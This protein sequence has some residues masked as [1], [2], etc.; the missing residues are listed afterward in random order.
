M[1]QSCHRV[2][3]GFTLIELVAVIIIIAVASAPL[4]GLFSQA[5]RSLLADETI[6]TATQLAQA[7]AEHLMAVRRNR[8]YADAEVSANL[9]ETLTGNYA[10]YSRVTTIAPYIGAACPGG[11]ACKQVSVRVDE[12]GQALAEIIFVLVNY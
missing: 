7:R 1:S 10:G 3:Q 9:T 12:S 6:Q 11:A 5:G 2:Q 4:F 8:G